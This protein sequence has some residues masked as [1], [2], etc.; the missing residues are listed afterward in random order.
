MEEITPLVNAIPSPSTQTPPAAPTP[1]APSAT[2]SAQG[3]S[4]AQIASQ[5][6][7][8]LDPEKL[9]KEISENVAGEVSKSVLTKIAEALGLTKKEE[10]K[11]P[12]DPEAL[13][14][15]VNEQVQARLAE[16]NKIREESDKVSQEE[17]QAKVNNTIKGW[18]A[19][20][21]QMASLGKVPRIANESDKN[22]RGV[23]SRRKIILAIGKVIEENKKQGVEYVP[24]ISDILI[25]YP[26][27]LSGLPGGDLPI[28]GNTVPSEPGGG[29]PYKTL[30]KMSIKDIARA[31]Q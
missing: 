25:Q 5:A 16:E 29:L 2:P 1:P 22:D 7:S 6:T 4:D 23:A 28:S 12:T 3:P 27:V 9:K 21:N 18:Y 10:A 11:L 15:L 17:Y 19:Q 24:S 14:A 20:Y 31:R 8:G 26:N 30:N 13:K